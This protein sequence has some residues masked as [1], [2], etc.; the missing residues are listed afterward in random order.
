MNI[1]T[2]LPALALFFAC[3]SYA[4]KAVDYDL[5]PDGIISVEEFNA[6]IRD[7][8]SKPLS[9]FDVNR[10]NK[11]DGAELTAAKTELDRVSEEIANFVVEFTDDVGDSGM[12]IA[13][14]ATLYA[15]DDAKDFSD[16][17]PPGLLGLRIRKNQESLLHGDKQ[18]TKA[19]GATISL[20][21]DIA[22]DNEVFTI[23]G[24]I[25]RPFN[26]KSDGSYIV[27]PGVEIN[28]VTNENNA[29]KETNSLVF[30]VANSFE[31]VTGWRSVQTLYTRVKPV[32]ATS[33]DFDIDVRALEIQLEPIATQWGFGTSV[34][35]L[36]GWQR[37]MRG[38]LH[39]EWGRV[40]DNGGNANLIEDETFARFG[41]KIALEL[42]HPNME[43]LLFGLSYEFLKDIGGDLR[44]RKRFEASMSYTLDAQERFSLSS[45]YVNGDSSVA[46]E[47]QSL[48]TAGLGIKF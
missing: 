42:S 2:L 3:D 48:W 34:E 35:T 40:Y 10:D 9:Y 27:V 11:L 39:F 16:Q 28:R 21:R 22:A 44:T 8:T 41:P 4:L 26:V 38:M 19:D 30:G 25:M 46:L 12:P 7:E 29:D 1:R 43:R 20:S 15:L 23:S 33:V 31:K 47:D 45:K 17:A 5:E 14:F 24:A 36:G 32:L 6:Y 37:Q 13:Q 18:T